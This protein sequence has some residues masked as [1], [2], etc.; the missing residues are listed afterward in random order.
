MKQHGGPMASVT[1]GPASSFRQE[2]R[3]AYQRRRRSCFIAQRPASAAVPTA[4]GIC[5]VPESALSGAGPYVDP[6][7]RPAPPGSSVTAR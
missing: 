1:A 6:G 5:P 4:P 7:G 3:M 2:A